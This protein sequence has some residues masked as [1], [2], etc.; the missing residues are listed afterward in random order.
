MPKSENDISGKVGMDTTDFKTGSILLNQQIKVIESGFKAAAAGMGDWGKSEEGLEARIKSLTGITELQRKKVENLTEE[1][2][3][4]AAEKG[5]DARASLDLQIKL[6]KQT[7]TLN[8]QERQLS[9][10]KTAL[11]NFG[12]E[13]DQESIKANKL[14]TQRV[15]LVQALKILAVK[16]AKQR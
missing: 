14:E 8:K 1:Y 7:E 6:N 16:L 10:T 9:E 13:M 11:N 15:K 4:V 12:K 5:D 3:R 2:Q